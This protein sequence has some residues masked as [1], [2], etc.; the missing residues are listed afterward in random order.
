MEHCLCSPCR[1][2]G[3]SVEPHGEAMRSQNIMAFEVCK[4]K[5]CNSR[6]ETTL[7]RAVKGIDVTTLEAIVAAASVG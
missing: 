6:S 4:P 5:S 1:W 2:R 7:N 3:P